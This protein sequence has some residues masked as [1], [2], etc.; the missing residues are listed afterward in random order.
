MLDAGKVGDCV[1]V[2]WEN[3][4]YDAYCGE[5]LYVGGIATN[6]VWAFN[7]LS[8]NNK[9]V[10]VDIE[11]NVYGGINLKGTLYAYGIRIVEDMRDL[12][13]PILKITDVIPSGSIEA[14]HAIDLSKIDLS[15]AVD[16]YTTQDSTA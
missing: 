9:I 8:G 6:G 1:N 14:D 13:G 3:P 16:W 15:E 4:A 11:N 12:P 7:G 5:F 2:V 10:N